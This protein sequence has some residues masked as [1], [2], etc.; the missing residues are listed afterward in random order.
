MTFCCVYNCSKNSDYHSSTGVHFHVFPGHIKLQTRFRS[1]I[2]YYKRKNINPGN[3]S[4]VCSKHFTTENYNQ[5]DLLQR[6][7]MHNSKI[8]IKLLPNAVPTDPHNLSHI[9]AS[10]SNSYP[11]KREK[12]YMSKNKKYI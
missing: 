7:L 8:K 6:K 9:S 11:N 3:E 4:R 1:W 5:S 2:N 10:D 12:R